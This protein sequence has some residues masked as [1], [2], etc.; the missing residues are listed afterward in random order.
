R[1]RGGRGRGAAGQAK[2]AAG[3]EGLTVAV[4]DVAGARRWLDRAPGAALAPV[5]RADLDAAGV[6]ATFGPHAVDFVAPRGAA[7]P[8]AAWLAVHGPSPYAATLRSPSS[9]GPLDPA[10]TLA[11]RLALA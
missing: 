9:K 5:E 10:R 8:L 6:R 11:P 2:G 3:L 7:G 4:A 1:P